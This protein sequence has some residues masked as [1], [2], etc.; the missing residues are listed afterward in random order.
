MPRYTKCYSEVDRNGPVMIGTPPT[1]KIKLRILQGGALQN[2]IANPPCRADGR[3]FH[4]LFLFHADIQETDSVLLKSV[5]DSK[6]RKLDNFGPNP[7]F[8]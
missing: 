1:T 7:S 5:I 2:P 8:L 6:V 4:L 3:K